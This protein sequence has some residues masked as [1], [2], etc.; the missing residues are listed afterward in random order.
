MKPAV[1]DAVAL[2]VAVAVPIGVGAAGSIATSSSVDSWYADLERPSWNPPS[3][4]FGPVWS[5]LYA[6]MGFASWLVW[7]RW[8]RGR[9]N[10][11]GDQARDALGAYGVQLVLNGLWSPVFFGAQRIG[12]GFLVI[13]MLWAALLE[14]VRRFRRVSL[15]AM[16]LMLPYLAWVTFAAALNGEIWRLN[17]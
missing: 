8:I 6:A 10:E 14:T 12:L 7:R 3:W 15:V 13:L 5:T 16:A 17:R 11:Q 9:G 2:G 1:R 4:V